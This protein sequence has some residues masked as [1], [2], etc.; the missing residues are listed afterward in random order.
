MLNA[1]YYSALAFA[2]IMILT[3]V[4]IKMTVK[5]GFT[6]KPRID[7]WHQKET[8][9]LGG[10]G[11]FI[12][13]IVPSFIFALQTGQNKALLFCLALI[14]L[15]GLVDDL[16]KISARAKLIGQILIAA[17]IVILSVNFSAPISLLVAIIMILWIVGIT[18]AFNLIDN[19][20]G[21]SAGIA[22]LTSLFLLIINFHFNQINP[23]IINAIFL[24]TM[25]GFLFYNSNPAKIF[26]G[27]AGSL[28]IGFYLATAAIS[29]I[30]QTNETPLKML[31]VALLI[32]LI[33]L[34]DMTFVV[35]MRKLNHQKIS[36]G[37]RDHTSHRLA[38]ITKSE[39]KPVLLLD[40]LSILGGATAVSLFRQNMIFFW[41]G[42][43]L[44]IFFIAYLIY[45]ITKVQ[46]YPPTKN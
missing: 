25:I 11:I 35:V 22:A 43:F 12:A 2:L 42:V 21:L 20:D 4:I 46:V 10:L 17:I 1:I 29:A 45:K 31:F 16:F 14:F 44:L 15:L 6:A 41:G 19:M 3:P 39:K 28:F 27:D 8:A 5:S 23:F 30:N 24:S 13:F 9:L 40:L 37:G 33:P 34:L 38:V 7:R 36:V 32:F 18:N 26:M